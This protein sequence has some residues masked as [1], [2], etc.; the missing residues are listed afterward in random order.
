MC[1]CVCVCVYIKT[2]NCQER[3]PDARSAVNNSFGETDLGNRCL[4]LA[5][6]STWAIRGAIKR[7]TTTSPFQLGSIYLRS[8]SVAR[9]LS[10]RGKR[11]Y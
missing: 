8:V 11:K 4:L 6:D 9:A 2:H 1:V 3:I 7:I 10:W 5:Y